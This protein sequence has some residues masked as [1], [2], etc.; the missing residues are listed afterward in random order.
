MLHR[1]TGL[2]GTLLLLLTL[3]L[4]G[5]GQVGTTTLTGEGAGG[6]T[7]SPTITSQPS[8]QSVSEGETA[9][10]A[11]VAT[12]SAPL[13]YQWR[14]N[15]VV[16][17]GA[18]SDTYSAPAS[19]EDDGATFSVVISNPAGTVES[20]T[21]KL[22]VMP[23]D[24]APSI[25]TEPADQSI[26]SGQTA[27]FSVV[28]SGSEPLTYQW[29]KNGTP[30]QGATQA[31]YTTGVQST[32]DNGALLAVSVSNALGTVTSRSARLGVSAST[33]GAVAPSIT[34][35]PA[36]ASIKAGQTATFAVSTTGTAPL[37]FQ[38]TRNGANIPGANASSYTTPPASASDSGAIFAVIVDNSVGYVTSRGARLTVSSAAPLITTQPAD[39]SVAAGKSATFTVVA[40]GTAP[41]SYQWH[42]NGVAI[43]GATSASFT[44]GSLGAGDSG[45]TFSVTVSNAA[46]KVT[47]RAAKLTVNG[48]APTITVQPTD[49]SVTSGKSATFSVVAQGTA[50]LTYQ[51]RRNGA[52]IAGAS[53]PS[54]TTPAVSRGDSGATF[55][56]LVT[57][58]SGTATSRT[59]TLTVTAG[60]AAPSITVQPADR[61]VTSGKSATFSVVAA[62][63]APLTY[64]WHRNGSP[65]GGATGSSYTTPATTTSDG[66]TTFSV[67]VTNAAGSVA[68]RAARLTVTAAASGPTI[69]TQPADQSLRS[70]Q[71]ATFSVV[72]AGSAPL[73][74]QWRRNGATLAGA[75]S[76]SYTTPTAGTSDSGAT[77]SVVVTN[78][79]GSV[80][81]RSALLTVTPV[82]TTAG[83][84]V[85]TYKNDP[86]RTGQNL[87]EK[88][89][90]PAN[91]KMSSFG[92]LRFLSTDG[93]VDAQPLYL[94]ALNVGGVSHNVVFVATESDS[95][96]AFDADTGAQ[97]WKA[98]LVPAG[99]TIMDEPPQY[100][101]VLQPTIGVTSTPVIDRRAGAHGTIY[102]VAMTKSSSSASWHQRLH[103]LDVSTGAEVAGG[104]TEITGSYPSAGGTITFDP[105]Q[106]LERAALLLVNHTIY[107]TWTS[108]CDNKFYTGWIMA[109][110]Q[111]SLRQ[112][113]VFNIAPNSGGTGPSIWMSGGGP[114]ADSAGNI[115]AITANGAFESTLNSDGFPNLG[116]Y[117]NSFIK[118]STSGGGLSVADYFAV[119]DTARLSAHDLDLGS[120]GI[121]LLPDM[122]DS[123]GTVRH[124]AVGAGKDGNLYV[125]NRDSMG[126]F[127]ASNNNIWQQ[128]S[129]VLGGGIWSTPAY[130]NGH[131]YY[132]AD[133]GNLKSFSI[134]GTKVS[135]A[136][137]SSTVT[138]GFPG[139]APAVS[140]NGTSNGI[141][142]AHQNSNPAVLYAFDAN[143]V[144]RMLYSSSQAANGRDQFGAGNKF[145]TPVIA[146]GKVF[147]GT[148]NGVAVFGLLN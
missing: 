76:S 99:E 6:V 18:D 4:V 50:P 108:H 33:A 48:S 22:T 123:T 42:R 142:W 112:T 88:T 1:R 27:T 148:T 19:S 141:V 86:A 144:S 34:A 78:A 24:V 7:L 66:G 74:Y 68:S 10:F 26:T 54:Y 84:D 37:I 2:A 129:A 53:G 116:D 55:S 8:S 93:K 69:T 110:N 85:V 20:A 61:S 138:F 145:I 96:Y 121:M 146:D 51:W 75:T 28:A 3:V 134:S 133:N 16:I 127:N 92:K 122:T 15:G 12:G 89:L 136:S 56:V 94:S 79:A 45:A 23:V 58:S 119:Y 82:V 100:C 117:G 36:D 124:L 81:S 114:A 118:L 111:S 107:T 135:P 104:P 72:A 95:V 103:A 106:Y 67:V 38:W 128:L 71:T 73:S 126:R 70:G 120:G 63:T 98:S 11:V 40:S 44:T 105:V 43:S 30:I 52:A 9:K 46:G 113:A 115:Y 97:L 83:T 41:L 14:K 109:Y 35:Q 90:T 64:Q 87:N 47:S 125:V 80:T 57:N 65:I 101:D 39:R 13:A 77:F 29:Q 131:I 91:V 60:V 5:C 147:V 17:A 49:Q 62:G 143:D 59:A 132:G 137:S 102:L 140:A 139:T 32:A 21:A 31:S 25:T 130:F